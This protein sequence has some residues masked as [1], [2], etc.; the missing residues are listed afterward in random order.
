MVEN[1]LGRVEPRRARVDCMG[2]PYCMSHSTYI[3]QGLSH[4]HNL[5]LQRTSL[6]AGAYTEEERGHPKKKGGLTLGPVGPWVGSESRTICK[7]KL[8][9][10]WVNPNKL[11]WP[12]VLS[13]HNRLAVG[14]IKMEISLDES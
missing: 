8:D 12:D 2:T 3:Q 10:D 5:C 1:L 13:K 6:D 7:I 14:W 11:S 9:W 4:S